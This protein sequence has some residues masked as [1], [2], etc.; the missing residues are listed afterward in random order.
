MAFQLIAQISRENFAK[1]RKLLDKYKPGL[2]IG[3]EKIYSDYFAT[4][5]I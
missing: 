5:P 4:K 2:P 3:F 1:T